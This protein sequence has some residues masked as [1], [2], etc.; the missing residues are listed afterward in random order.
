MYRGAGPSTLCNANGSPVQNKEFN[1]LKVRNGSNAG[2]W[3][4]ESG[5]LVLRPRDSEGVHFL[6]TE[7]APRTLRNAS[8][9][10]GNSWNWRVNLSSV[11]HASGG[12]GAATT[13]AAGGARIELS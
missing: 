5:A 2:S 1:P 11:C 6:Y 3:R 13:C 12:A 9:A 7:G 8:S 4:D 10:A